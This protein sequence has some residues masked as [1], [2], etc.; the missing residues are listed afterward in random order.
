MMTNRRFLFAL[1]V[2]CLAAVFSYIRNA[3]TG[4]AWDL[5][6]PLA[7]AGELFSGR[8]PYARLYPFSPHPQYWTLFYPLPALAL[9]SPLAWLP[10]PL[11]GAL[12]FGGVSGVLAY[13]RRSPLLFL[14]YPYAACLASCQVWPVLTSAAFVIPALAP[15]ALAKPNL[16]AALLLARP[17]KQWRGALVVG[18]LILLSIPL[19][20][21]QALPQHESSAPILTAAGALAAL[22]ILRFRDPRARLLLTM[23]CLPQ[24]AYDSLPVA[25]T[26]PL[27]LILGWLLFPFY[28]FDAPMGAVG[29]AIYVPALVGIFA[30]SS[31]YASIRAAM[32]R[33]S[34]SS[35]L[36]RT[37]DT[38]ASTSDAIRSST[39]R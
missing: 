12:A 10:Y 17:P 9:L 8:N 20:W 34:R 3:Q 35:A 24:R 36:R 27:S 29:A 15:L 38:S 21:L 4:L 22:A 19:G 16:G 25:G 11:A 7:G 39:L 2:G 32:I 18:L 28:G 23:A 5:T 33:M 37:A 14:S 26:A 1:G 6:W 30:S 31:S 13:A